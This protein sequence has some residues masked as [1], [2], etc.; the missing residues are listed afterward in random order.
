MENANKGQRS[1]KLSKIHKLLQKIYSKLQL[2]GKTIEQA[3]MKEEMDMDR[4]TPM[5]IWRIK[6]EN[7]MSAY[8]LPSEK[9]R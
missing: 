3:K 5:G 4:W 1:R 6:E 9:G 7:N 2:Y 8:I